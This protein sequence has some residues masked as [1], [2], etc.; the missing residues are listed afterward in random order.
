VVDAAAEG[1]YTQDVRIDADPDVVFDF[2]V[3]GDQMVR[4]MGVSAKLDPIPGGQF[5]IDVNGRD[6]A[7]GQFLEVDRPHR[8]LMTW[9]WEDSEVMPPGSTEVEITLVAE[10]AGTLLRFEHRLVPADQVAPH[11]EGWNYYLPRLATAAAGGDPGPSQ[12][13]HE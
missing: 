10:P 2:L 3:D 8:V 12:L 5:R 11:T 13:G 1:I 4:W 9:G 7:I 6:I